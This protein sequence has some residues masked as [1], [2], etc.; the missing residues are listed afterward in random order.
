MSE[1][2]KY[3]DIIRL[4]HG[5]TVG[6]LNPGDYIIITEKID[7]ANTSFGLNLEKENKLDLYSRR[8]EVNKDNTLRGFYGWSLEN[9]DT[10]L[11]EPDYIYYGAWLC[12]HTVKYRP[13]CYQKF[14]LFNIYDSK[15]QEYLSWE[16]VEKESDY[17]GLLTP[18]LFYKGEYISFEHLMSYVGKTEMAIDYG[19]GIVVKNY[20]YKDRNN[21][22][23]FVKL[24]HE[25]FI[26]VQKQKDPKDPNRPK[27]LEAEFV[28]V[29]VTKPRIHKIL[30]KLVDEGVF[31]LSFGI[32]DMKFILKNVNPIVYEDIMKEEASMLPE[33]YEI[34]KTLLGRAIASRVPV[35]IKEIL[36]D[37]I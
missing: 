20:K 34:D 27:S 36:S 8:I 6:V 26:E 30:L 12:S 10:D 28:N 21:N 2:K 11:L 33:N 13:D 9:I 1:F 3:M 25:N 5:S 37:K 23:V 14:Y 29:C 16:E 17:L 32:E 22:Q 18:P 31:P 15:K 7:G 4:G 24:V 35:L 19:E